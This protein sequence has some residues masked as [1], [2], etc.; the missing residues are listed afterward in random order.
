MSLFTRC[1]LQITAPTQDKLESF[2]SK[3]FKDVEPSTDEDSESYQFFHEGYLTADNLIATGYTDIVD[4]TT[5]KFSFR[6]IK[7]PPVDQIKKLIQEYFNFEF[8]LVTKY[9]DFDSLYILEGRNCEIVETTQFDKED[10]LDNEVYDFMWTE[11]VYEA[12]LQMPQKQYDQFIDFTNINRQN[13]E[14][15]SKN[16]SMK[17]SV[18]LYNAAIKYGNVEDDEF[19]ELF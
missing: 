10:Y 6:T 13:L 16:K 17:I 3:H 14:Q 7:K 18:D 4:E 5:I 15:I 1:T 2:I 12:L 19:D 11:H 8:K 9:H